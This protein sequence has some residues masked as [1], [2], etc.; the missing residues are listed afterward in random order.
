MKSSILK[1][2]LAPRL[3]NKK[4]KLPPVVHLLLPPIGTLPSQLAVHPLELVQDGSTCKKN[5]SPCA[6]SIKLAVNN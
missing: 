5:N 6:S 4:L 2:A 1:K 3:F